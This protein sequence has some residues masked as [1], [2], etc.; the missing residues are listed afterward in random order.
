MQP[1]SRQVCCKKILYEL[2]V[3]KLVSLERA[4]KAVHYG[5]EKKNLNRLN[6]ILKTFGGFPALQTTQKYQT[7]ENVVEKLRKLGAGYSGVFILDVTVDSTDSSRNLLEIQDGELLM[8][9]RKAYIEKGKDINAYRNLLVSVAMLLQDKHVTRKEIEREVDAVIEF[10]TEMAKVHNNNSGDED[11]RKGTTP[12]LADKFE[13]RARYESG[14][15]YWNPKK[16]NN[17]MNLKTLQSLAPSINW[18]S[19][20]N[21]LTGQNI[22]EDEIIIN[23]KNPQY[24][25]KMANV[26]QDT[27]LRTVVNYMLWKFV[28]NNLK[29][30]GPKFINLRKIYAKITSGKK[31]NKL[32]DRICFDHVVPAYDK[33]CM[34]PAV[35][36]IYLKNYFPEKNDKMS[37]KIMEL[38]HD[39]GIVL[40]LKQLV[41]SWTNW[42]A[43]MD[44]PF[45]IR[46]EEIPS[47][48]ADFPIFNVL[49]ADSTSILVVSGIWSSSS[50]EKEYVGCIFLELLQSWMDISTKRD[51]INKLD[52]MRFF[53]Y[54]EELKN[55]KILNDLCSKVK[56]G[57][58]FM[59]NFLSVEKDKENRKFTQLRKSSEEGMW[60]LKADTKSVN[61][62]YSP[63]F[64]AI[65]KSMNYGGIGWIIGHE[66]SHGFDVNGRKFGRNGNLH[67]W[68]SDGTLSRYNKKVD[69]FKEEFGKYNYPL[70]GDTKLNAHA[71]IA[72][73]LADA[74]G[75][76]SSYEVFT[77]KSKGMSK[78]APKI[79][80]DFTDRQLYWIAYAQSQCSKATKQERARSQLEDAHPPSQIRINGIVKHSEQFQLDFNCRS[81]DDMNA[82]KKCSLWT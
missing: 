2:I 34:V 47:S 52:S 54:P 46:V 73:I 56:V 66:I 30:I 13:I 79:F 19:H 26:I 68:W 27:P 24:V 11:G 57:D 58:N 16:T 67:E 28:Y 44:P 82:K 40:C 49:M 14:A 71:T 8:P 10:E 43:I 15:D 23:V 81:C 1:V 36:S 64:N 50:S 41:K 48:P 32:K 12:K 37:S 55:I 25:N 39:L 38:H 42:A 59:S 70:L 18:K 65:R 61:A 31:S 17:K 80:G 35:S 69:C 63:S 60:L 78:S 21:A 20:L 45:L 75:V 5:S 7:Y 6:E 4:L 76:M 9:T 72:E 22:R 62:F 3:I 33:S 74:A 77:S 53:M 29:I 51:A